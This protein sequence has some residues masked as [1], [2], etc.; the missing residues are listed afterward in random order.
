M[1]NILCFVM[2]KVCFYIH[3]LEVLEYYSCYTF[4]LR[5]DIITAV[6]H[7]MQGVGYHFL[8]PLIKKDIFFKH[9]FKNLFYYIPIYSIE[10]EKYKTFFL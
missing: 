6:K 3:Y 9:I 2:E 4:F 5:H 8:E 1:L 7:K 10:L